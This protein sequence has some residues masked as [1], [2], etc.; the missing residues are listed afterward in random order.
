MPTWDRPIT[1]GLLAAG[2]LY[3]LLSIPSYLSFAESMSTGLENA[4][5]SGVEIG[6][7]ANLAGI[8]LLVVHAALLV[9]A[10]GLSVRF[11]RLGRIAFWIPL[12][13]ALLF[14]VASIAIGVIPLLLDP[15]ILAAMRN[16]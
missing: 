2:V 8:V 15:S 1:V 14:G 6:S 12:V 10:V 3:L 5:Y 11:L 9:A 4:G 7:G 13:G 16:R